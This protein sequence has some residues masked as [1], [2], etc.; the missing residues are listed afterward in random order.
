MLGNIDSVVD[1]QA[2]GTQRFTCIEGSMTW[3]SCTNPFQSPLAVFH[4][5]GNARGFGS[6]ALIEE[7]I[8]LFGISG[9]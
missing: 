2:P 7:L 5:V 9:F 6:S 4:R 8:D 1:G 3:Y